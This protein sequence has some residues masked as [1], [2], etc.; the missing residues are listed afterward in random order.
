MNLLEKT[1]NDMKKEETKEVTVSMWWFN[2]CDIPHHIYYNTLY[3]Q[4]KLALIAPHEMKLL[5]F[6]MKE[7]LIPLIKQWSNGN[8]LIFGMT[9]NSVQT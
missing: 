3:L 2:D 7:N 1:Y 8:V 4:D 5:T 6:Q 9:G